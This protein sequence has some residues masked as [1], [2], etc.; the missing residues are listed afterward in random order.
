MY[1]G[2]F[3]HGII[4]GVR[5]ATDAQ[6]LGFVH[7]GF[8]DL[9]F[10]GEP[11]T[12]VE[13]IKGLKMRS[14]ENFVWIRMFEL[15]GT[16]PTPVTWGE[17]FTAMQT[18]VADGLDTPASAALDNN[19]DEVTQSMV[20]TGDMF[21]SMMIAMNATK[22]DALTAEHQAVMREAVTEMGVWMDNEVTIPA[23]KTAYGRLEEAGVKV[24][25]AENIE[26]WRAAMA[27]MYDEV[28]ARYPGADEY[29]E[30]LLAE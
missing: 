20:K 29:I 30:M 18:G 23:E 28:R 10:A 9:L 15:L 1:N 4:D 13:S 21:G 5:A 12:S 2:E 11:R 6:I 24:C 3:G 25:E 8:R 22:F 19:F 27:P 26:A 14:P 17:V 7:V 16:Q